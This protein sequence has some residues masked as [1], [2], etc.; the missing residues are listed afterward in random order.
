MQPISVVIITLNEEKNIECC[1]T[2]VK[3]FA[4][5][6]VVVD[7]LSTDKTA[8]LAEKAGARV[9]LQAFLGHIEQKNFAIGHTAHRLVFSI[10]ADEVVSDELCQ[11]I[12]KVK[13]QADADAWSMNRLNNY[14][15]KW[16][17]HSGWYPDRKIRLFDKNLARWGGRNPH[18]RILIDK[19]GVVRQ[20][21]G[22]LL[23]YTYHTIG[24]HLLQAD[25]FA[26][27]AAKALFDEGKR[28]W[29]CQLLIKP[30]A[31]FLRNYILKF[32]F[33][34]GYYGF[35]ICRIAAYETF[36][37]Y[38]RLREFHRENKS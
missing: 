23:H 15:G 32:G 22:D 21:S 17:R 2:S 4:D 8:E 33:L 1:I 35:V 26:T 28:A 31:K 19:G 27:I 12:L 20:I 5:E 10:D 37:K 13:R 30:T 25:K 18:D 16:I 7:S 38:K 34:D 11:S 9:V 29:P 14:C 36:L 24:E 6:I 3:P